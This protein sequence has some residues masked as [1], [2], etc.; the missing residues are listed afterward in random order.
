MIY[1][2]RPQPTKEI[3]F[4]NINILVKLIKTLWF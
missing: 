1:W 2:N 3:Y 4:N